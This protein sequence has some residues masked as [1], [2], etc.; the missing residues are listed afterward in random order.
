[1]VAGW[2]NRK[3]LAPMTF[4][5]HCDT[6]L[7]EAWVEQ[8]LVPDLSAGQVVVMDNASFHKSQRMFDKAE[9]L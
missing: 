2:C 9:R 5:G 4:E 7:F 6:W 1:M 3:V 8:C